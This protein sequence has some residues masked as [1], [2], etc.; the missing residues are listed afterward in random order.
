MNR[1]TTLP[2]NILSLC[3]RFLEYLDGNVNIQ[4]GLLDFSYTERGTAAHLVQEIRS[5]LLEC[6]LKPSNVRGQSYD[7]TSAMTSDKQGVQGLFRKEVPRAVYTPCNTHKLNLVVASSSKLPQIRH[8]VTAVNE[9]HLFLSASHKRQGFFE[10]VIV[11][12]HSRD[13]GQ[14][15]RQQ[16]LKGLCKT[17]WVER[18]EAFDNFIDMVPFVM[19]TCDIIVNLHL[20]QQ[21]AENQSSN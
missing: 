15:S 12:L 4:E 21:D 6:G 20:Y 17:R 8:C 16:K 5:K 3:K 11:I 9:E 14:H 13:E 10:K 19:T 7:T 2:T 18:F 1:R